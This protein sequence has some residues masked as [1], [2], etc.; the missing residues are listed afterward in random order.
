MLVTIFQLTTCHNKE[1]LNLTNYHWKNLIYCQLNKLELYHQA[2]NT[3]YKC[4][5]MLPWT[6]IC[7]RVTYH[8][9]PNIALSSHPNFLPVA[10]WI[11]NRFFHGSSILLSSSGKSYWSIINTTIRNIHWFILFKQM[12]TDYKSVI[13]PCWHHQQLSCIASDVY[14]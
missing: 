10:S 13:L 14:F 11:M 6:D 12:S 1:D 8:E 7:K 4:Y 3:R 2:Y 5:N 9:C